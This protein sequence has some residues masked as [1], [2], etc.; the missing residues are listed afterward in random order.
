L[1]P[2][3]ICY[4]NFMQFTESVE[5][6]LEMIFILGN[7]KEEVH[8]VD[9]ANSMKFSRASVSIALKKM[10]QNNLVEIDENGHITLTA[11][12][13]TIALTVYEKHE[14]IS[15]WLMSLGV[16]EKTAVEDACRIEHVLSADSFNAIKEFIKNRT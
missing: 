16:N 7:A 1:P 15:S 14:I 10:R 13:M 9:I 2:P 12:G 4:N 3:H 6:Y 5:N 8:S 11:K